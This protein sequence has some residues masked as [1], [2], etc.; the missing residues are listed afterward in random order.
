MGAVK[1]RLSFVSLVSLL[2]S[3]GGGGGGSPMTTAAPPSTQASSPGNAYFYQDV[4]N[5]ANT[6]RAGFTSDMRVVTPYNAQ[7]VQWQVLGGQARIYGDPVMSRLSN[8]RWAM[9]AGTSNVDPRGAN[10]MMY[11][12]ASC[13]RVDDAAVK[14]VGRSSASGCNTQGTGGWVGAKFSGIFDVSGSNYVFVM[15]DGR[16]HLM[17]LTDATHTA[18]DIASVCVRS[19]R[20]P[21]FSA[22]QWAEATLVI[23]DTLAAGLRLSDTAVARRRDGTWVLFVKGIA[24][25]TT[26]AQASL[27]ELCARGIYRTTSTD[28]VNWSALQR[29][30][31]QASVP[32]ASVAPDGT[33]WLYWQSFAEACAAQDV[34]VASRA[35]IRA[36]ADSA[37]FT[38]GVPVAVSFTG[39]AFETNT[40][41]HYPTN[42]NPVYLPDAA[43]KSALD[44]CFGR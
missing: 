23:D 14:I 38:L 18:S 30:V 2:V 5:A 41:L 17:R 25:S 20:A 8:G 7:V 12:E 35:P 29:V 40:Q 31:D 39:E 26:C 43:A 33:V 3:C 10:A 6:V 34:L 9:M 37:T 24:S 28:L 1:A 21:T 19:T 36:A 32:D 42:G 16:I 13:P 15:I 27:C 22:L 11:Y 44:A 4:N